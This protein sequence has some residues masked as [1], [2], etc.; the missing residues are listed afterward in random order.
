MGV[1]LSLSRPRS[2][3]VWSG[4]VCGGEAGHVEHKVE[5]SVDSC[6]GGVVCC[7]LA[8]VSLGYCGGFGVW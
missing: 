7:G 3:Q 1:S 5:V 6:L 2:R 4:G 8:G